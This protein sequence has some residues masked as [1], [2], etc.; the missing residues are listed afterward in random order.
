M[1]VFG[2]RSRE[3][4]DKARESSLRLEMS[5]RKAGWMIGGED[6]GDGVISN[7]RVRDGEEKGVMVRVMVRVI[8]RV[9][10]KV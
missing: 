4:R 5:R 6:E 3:G 10:V 9:R 2:G 7:P 1:Q 8:V